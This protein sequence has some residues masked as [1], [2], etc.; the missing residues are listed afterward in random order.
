MMNALRGEE[1]SN[2]EL[3]FKMKNNEVRYLLVNAT[4][5]RDEKNNVIGGKT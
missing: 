4:T 3:E 1:K 5:R 2:Y